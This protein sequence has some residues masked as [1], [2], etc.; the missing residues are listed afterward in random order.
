MHTCIG[1]GN[2]EH[3]QCKAAKH[4]VEATYTGRLVV[5]WRNP[6][7]SMSRHKLNYNEFEAHVNGFRTEPE[8]ERIQQCTPRPC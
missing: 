3:E 2:Y 1:D 7:D 8:L 4:C 6:R 5:E